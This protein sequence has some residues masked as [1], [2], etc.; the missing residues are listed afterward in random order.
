MVSVVKKLLP[1]AAGTAGA[2]GG[3]DDFN[4]VQTLI[5][6]DGSDGAHNTTG[7]VDSSSNG[8]TVT[9][10][11]GNVFQGTFSPFSKD[12]GKWSVY[13][14]QG[15]TT[16]QIYV[17]PASTADLSPGTSAFT[18]EAWV[19]ITADTYPYS[20]VCNFGPYWNNNNSI[21]L[22]VNDTANSDKIS[23]AAYAAGGNTRTCVSQNATPMNQW[24]HIAVTRDTT[25]DF[26]L[27]I[28]GNLDATNTSYRTTDLSSGGS[29]TLAIGNGMNRAVEEPFEGYISNFRFVK[30]TAVYT[31]SF[32]V[33]TEPLTAI[34]NTKLLTCCSN[35]FMDK[36]PGADVTSQS[37]G[38]PKVRPFSPYKNS[39]KYDP[40]VHGGSAYFGG[41]ASNY[42]KMDHAS[43]FDFGTTDHCLEMWVY[44]TETTYKTGVNQWRLI[45]DLEGNNNYWGWTTQNI[46]GQG[47]GLTIH[48]DTL[49][50]YS[51]ATTE[52]PIP[53]SWNHIVYQFTGGRT[54]WYVNGTRVYDATR[55]HSWSD[56]TGIRIGN[57]GN[58]NDYFYKGFATDF[59]VT[60]GANY[61]PYSN[62]ATLTVP[63]APLTSGSYTRGLLNFATTAIRDEAGGNQLNTIGNTPI[64]TSIKKFGTGSMEFNHSSHYV[65]LNNETFRPFGTGDFTIEC[66]AYFNTTPNG[67]G[68]GVFQ[69]SNGY[70]NATTRGPAAG[71]SNST[72]KWG[73][74]Y[75]TSWSGDLASASVPSINTWYHMAYVRHSGTSKL[76]VDGVEQLSI[77][78]TTNYTDTYFTIGGWYDGNYLMSGRIDEFRITHKARYTSNNFDVPTSA[79]PD[80]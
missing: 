45:A 70:L 26:R 73:I 80:I 48:T 10:N 62:A 8:L 66:W 47:G 24:V 68:Q 76:Y 54:N 34:T 69:L 78:D 74:Y 61:N 23:F 77:S 63:T 1:G 58:Y 43:L 7:F 46:G 50:T 12:E 33:P 57:S 35:R 39:A 28:N 22:V 65:T 71:C 60:T 21:A 79:L 15:V 38:Y 20:R 75:G 67:N 37:S 30:G 5:H 11:G 9:N 18:L 36:G 2:G 17:N 29:Q 49:D 13:F 3:D 32:D 52:M 53:Y 72:G 59:R 40:A 64:D 42:V 19:Y 14:P 55:A 6:A 31:S 27:F 41:A 56:A 4:L 44:P 51:G 16:N 25:G